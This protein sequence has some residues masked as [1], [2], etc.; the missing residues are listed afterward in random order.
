MGSWR[1]VKNEPDVFRSLR[2]KSSR[3]DETGA[4][5]ALTDLINRCISERTPAEVSHV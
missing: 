3:A 2:A 5:F 1:E 4:Q